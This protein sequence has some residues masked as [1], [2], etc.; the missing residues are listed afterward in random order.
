MNLKN[1]NQISFERKDLL[2]EQYFKF[3]NESDIYRTF[4]KYFHII[5]IINNIIFDINLQN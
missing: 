2:N 5:L 1:K 4:I 3:A